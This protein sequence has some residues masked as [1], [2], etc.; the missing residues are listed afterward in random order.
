MYSHFALLG[1]SEHQQPHGKLTHAYRIVNPAARAKENFKES[2]FMFGG[3]KIDSKPTAVS[4]RV[5]EYNDSSDPTSFRNFLRKHPN[6]FVWF[7]ATWCGHCTAMK[8][9]FDQAAEVVQNVSFIKVDA[10]QHKPLIQFY[11]VVGFPTLKLFMDGDQ[12]VEY[13]E[14]RNASSFINWLRQQV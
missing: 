10:E 13:E 5:I 7:H 2:F 6:A 12:I 9:D 8:D 3:E 4:S 14:R 1:Y 11:N